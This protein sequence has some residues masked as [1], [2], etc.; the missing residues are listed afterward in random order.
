[1]KQKFNIVVLLF[2][3]LAIISC[4]SEDAPDCFKSAGAT[5]AYD[6]VAGDFTGINISEGLEV[7]ITEG[8]ATKVTI[9]TGEYVRGDI[10]AEVIDNTLYLRNSSSCNWVRDYNTTKVYITTPQLETIY[11]ASQFSVRSRGIVNFPTLKLQSGL[12]GESAS[13]NFELNVNAETLMVDD[14]QSAYYKVVGTVNNLHVNFYS[15]DA[16]FEGSGLTAQKVTVFHRSSNDMIVHPVQE[17]RGTLYSTG[18][19]I[20]KNQPPILEVERLYTG[21]VFFQ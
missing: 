4:N 1:M 20:L 5:I 7:E 13:G 14:N 21:A 3:A 18:N 6:V 8:T 9:E 11:S 15:G 19:L 10:S 16:R 2:I 17:V 12:F